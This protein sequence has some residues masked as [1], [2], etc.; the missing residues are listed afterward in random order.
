MKLHK[1][2]KY[3][4]LLSVFLCL[5]AES[6]DTPQ[7]TAEQKQTAKTTQSLNEADRQLGMPAII[8]FQEKRMMKELYEKRDTKLA[9]HSYIVNQMKGCLV[10]LGASIGYGM[11]YATQYSNPQ[12]TVFEGGLQRGFGSLPQAEPNGLYMPS[13]AH[14]TWVMLY[15]AETKQADP[16]YIEPDVI[17]SPFRL[18]KQECGV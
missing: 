1:S 15:N 17:V 2:I 6:C 13:D 16:V 7:P 12:R 14:G 5:T 8:N 4:S 11:P 9:T 18:T 10:Y 3:I